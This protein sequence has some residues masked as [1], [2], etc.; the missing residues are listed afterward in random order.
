[1]GTGEVLGGGGGGHHVH[2]RSMYIIKTNW[3]DESGALCFAVAP[4]IYL[5]MSP[6]SVC[7]HVCVDVWNFTPLGDPTARPLGSEEDGYDC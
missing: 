3:P 1:M 7:L 2:C 4:V 6:M 5:V